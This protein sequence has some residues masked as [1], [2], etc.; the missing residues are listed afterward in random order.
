MFVLKQK[1]GQRHVKIQSQEH[2]N[3]INNLHIIKNKASNPRV[4]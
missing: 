2:E 4:F 1:A 3:Q